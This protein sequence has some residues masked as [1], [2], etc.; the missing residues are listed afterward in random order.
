MLRRSVVA[1]GLVLAPRPVQAQPAA[2]HAELRVA[3][4]VNDVDHMRLAIAAAGVR[5]QLAPTFEAGVVA[6]A[7]ATDGTADLGAPAPR[8]FGGELAARVVPWPDAVVRPYAK[9]ALGALLFLEEPFLPGGDFYE[10][11]ITFGAGAEI[12]PAARWTAAVDVF[13]VHLSNGQGLGAFNPAYDG[14][15]VTLG[16]GY[17]LGDVRAPPR[18]T[19]PAPE[20]TP[21]HDLIIDASVGATGD[22]TL[23][24]GRIR[25]STGIGDHAIAALDVEA[26]TLAGTAFVEAG[27]ELIGRMARVRAGLHA[28]YRRYAGANTAVFTAQVEARATPELDVI[29]M[30]HH[31]RSD[32]FGTVWRAALGMRLT[33]MSTLVV[34]LG[35]GFDR[36]GDDTVFDGDHSDPYIALEWRAPW[37]LADRRLA[38]FI[39]RQVSTLGIIGVRF[40]STAPAWRR[41]R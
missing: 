33:P 12:R 6:L 40:T 38:V 23:Y 11:I 1:L 16:V 28:G 20:P 36:I 19:A 27:G 15:G 5:W 22:A 30:G 25:P 14:Y 4:G 13:M 21:R 24:S 39:E 29:A 34:D 9:A 32:V 26:G 41:V 3:D 37:D 10:G 17:A 31:E 18:S 2:L 8:G 7:L 35:I